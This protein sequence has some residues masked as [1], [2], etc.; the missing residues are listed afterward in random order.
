[1][2]RACFRS[3]CPG[4]IRRAWQWSDVSTR[5]TRGTSW[6]RF[7]HVIYAIYICVCMSCDGDV[8]IYSILS[9]F[10]HIHTN[11][12]FPFGDI[13]YYN[14]YNIKEHHHHYHYNPRIF[15]RRCAVSFLIIS[16]SFSYAFNWLYSNNPS[17]YI[18]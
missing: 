2:R 10:V 5:G 13:T 6:K 18:T 9:F 7:H 1:M 12:S 4:Q 17:H 14:V 8:Y 15:T 11:A 3:V 16:S